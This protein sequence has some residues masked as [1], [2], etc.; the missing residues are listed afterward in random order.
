MKIFQE[1]MED[2]QVRRL[3]QSDAENVLALMKTNPGYF[4][5]LQEKEVTYEQVIEDMTELPPNTDASAKYFVGFYQNDKLDAIMDYIDGYPEKNTLFIG[6]FMIHGINQG[7]GYGKRIMLD[8]MRRAKLDGYEFVRL[9]CV[10]H[11]KEGFAFWSS[12]GFTEI[13][14]VVSS[15]ENRKDWNVIIM[16]Y[17]L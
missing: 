6:L 5:Y 9:G 11:N 1:N 17:S 12:L 15:G 10:D 14:R 7:K 16:Q 13:K 3:D 2:Y 4:S 8:F